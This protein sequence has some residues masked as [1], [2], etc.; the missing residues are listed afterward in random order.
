M[1]VKRTAVRVRISRRI[2]W[3]GSEA[4]PLSHVVRIHPVQLRLK[5]LP[6]FVDFGRRA[7]ATIMFAVLGAIAMAKLGRA[8][9]TAAWVV[10]WPIVGGLLVFHLAGLVRLLRLPRVYVLRVAMAGS[11]E[12]A[13][14]STDKAQIDELT[15]QVTDAIDNPAAEFEVRVDNLEF[16]Y[17]DKVGGDKVLGDK[18][19]FEGSN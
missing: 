4:Y 8:L 13:V 1:K 19:I 3:V 6:I 5:R 9:P 16:V 15:M 12:A 17:G 11:E 10:F 2:L 7:G 18:K 14:V